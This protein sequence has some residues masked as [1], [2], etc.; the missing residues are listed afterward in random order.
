MSSH[1]TSSESA[2]RF[3]SRLIVT[4]AIRTRERTRMPVRCGFHHRGDYALAAPAACRTAGNGVVTE[5]NPPLITASLRLEPLRREHASA[6]F[7]VLAPR[8]LR[9][10]DGP[11]TPRTGLLL[12]TGT[13]DSNP[14]TRPTRANCG[15]TGSSCSTRRRS[16]PCRQRL[17]R[18]KR[19]AW[20]AT[21][22]I[23]P[24]GRGSATEAV[25][26]WSNIFTATSSAN[27]PRDR[28]RAQ[29]AVAAP[30]RTPRLRAHRHRDR[31]I[32]GHPGRR[33]HRRMPPRLR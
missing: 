18:R 13:A 5:V 33:P 29:H 9:L 2:L 25:A 19:R 21:S 7:A 22:F 1:I 31:G 14:G 10:F 8:H 12:P 26:P 20:W 30:S 3:S 11:T 17:G 32:T 27:G 28:R 23:P 4:V 24:W 15:S 16:E 6:M